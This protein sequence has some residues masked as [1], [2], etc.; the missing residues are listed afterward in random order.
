MLTSAGAFAV[1]LAGIPLIS[2]GAFTARDEH[3][4]ILGF[5]M[6]LTLVCLGSGLL[7][8]VIGIVALM[9]RNGEEQGTRLDL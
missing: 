8:V 4:W 6:L 3:G 1:S 2:F 5:I 7:L 9:R